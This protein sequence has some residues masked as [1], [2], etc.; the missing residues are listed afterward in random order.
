LVLVGLIRVNRIEMSCDIIFLT[1]L[2]GKLWQRA[3]GPYQLASFLRQHGFSVQVIDFTDYFSIDEL[4]ETIEQFI[5]SNTKILGV[6]STFYQK[7]IP[8]DDLGKN[9][10]YVRGSIGILPDNVVESV[11]YIKQKYPKIKTIVGGGKSGNFE[12]DT[13]FDV[14]I[15][16]Y[17]ETVFLDYLTKKNIYPRI[18]TTEII[19]G[20]GSKFDIENMHHSWHPNDIIL[21]SET[22]P[23]EIGRGCIFKC[24]F[25][26]YP[27]NGKK[28]YDYLRNAKTI[29]DEIKENYEK[30][31]V[32]NYLFADDTFN[33]SVYK[34]DK[35]NNELDKLSFKINFTTYLRLDL[36]Y[37][38]REQLPLLKNLG[39][40]SAFF[41]IE[42]LNEETGKIIGKGMHPNKVKEFLLELKNEIWKDDISML[43]TFI[44]GLPKETI[45]STDNS[46]N[47][48]KENGINSAWTPL[49]I[50]VKDRYKSDIALNYENY[51]YTITDKY[52]G[53]WINDLTTFDEANVAAE[54][55]NEYALPNNYI[56][57]WILFNL[58]SYQI[59]NIDQLHKIQNKDFPRELYNSRHQEMIKEYKN[60]IKKI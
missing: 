17:A 33:D 46:F 1:C 14:V 56:T 24:K 12:G 30:Y 52:K 15:H 13:L 9:K 19:N 41:G 27:L 57:S 55:Y 40:R 6:S 34:L 58:L 60:R 7:E 2:T 20:D 59:H 26:G 8:Q 32:T 4:K 54:R 3:I 11:K 45:E 37:A 29:S 53:R 10:K 39:L 35:L 50:N 22:L 25:C 38:H 44:V 5:G 47:W 48:I 51:G 28:K 31:G 16:G 21:P 36:L 18:S 42:S 23:I 43:C 49:Y